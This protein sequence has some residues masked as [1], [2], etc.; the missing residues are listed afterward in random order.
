MV[1]LFLFIIFWRIED[2]DMTEFIAVSEKFRDV[3]IQ[4][5]PPI[6]LLEISKS[7]NRIVAYNKEMEIYVND[8]I[9]L[10]KQAIVLDGINKTRK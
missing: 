8:A 9:A 5:L 10:M 4:K 2:M 6:L 3:D 1:P 7:N